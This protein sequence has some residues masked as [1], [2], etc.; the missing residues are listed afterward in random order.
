MNAQLESA[1]DLVI[2]RRFNAARERVWKAWTDPVQVMRWW[3]PNAFVS[4]FCDIDFRIGGKYLFCM[5]SDEGPEIWKKGIWSTGE[6]LEIEPMTKIVCTD[7]FAD[8]KGNVVSGSYYGMDEFPLA[9]E[10]AVTFSDAG[11]GETEMTL[12]HRGL[13]VSMI[14]ECRTGW[15]ESFDKLEASLRQD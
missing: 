1:G 11:E 14:D 15:Q 5:Q 7:S 4:P 13:P 6:Y 9:L 2:T 8:E 12:R 10:I 3:G